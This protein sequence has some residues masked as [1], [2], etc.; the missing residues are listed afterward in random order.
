MFESIYHAFNTNYAQ[1]KEIAPHLADLGFTHIQFPPIQRTRVL[2]GSDLPLLQGQIKARE[3]HLQEYESL[4]LKARAKE[5]AYPNHTFTYLLEQRIYYI[6]QPLLRAIYSG[7]LAGSCNTKTKVDWVFS[8]GAWKRSRAAQIILSVYASKAPKKYPY[9][10]LYREAEL[11]VN[12]PT[13]PRADPGLQTKLADA[14][15]THQ[16]I[17][18]RIKSCS[19]GTVH[20]DLLQQSAECKKSY[21]RLKSLESLHI[22]YEKS[23][24]ELATL[25]AAATELRKQCLNDFS[26]VDVPL[27][28]HQAWS[29]LFNIICVAEFLLHPPWWMIYQPVRLA[30]GTTMH[31]DTDELYNAIHACKRAGLYVIAD[32]VVNNFAAIAG[33]RDDWQPYAQNRGAQTLADTDAVNSVTGKK[34]QTLLLDA[35][36]TD[37]LSA[38]TPPFECTTGQD[39]TQCWMSGALPQLNQDHPAVSEQQ[40]KF[41]ITLRGMGIDGVR[42][43]AAAHLR[44]ADCVR[45]IAMFPG[46]SYIE[47]VGGSESWRAYPDRAYSSVARLEDFAI[48]EDL[49]KHIFSEQ[50]Q[51]ERIKNYGHVRLQRHENLDSVVMIVNHD[52][53]MGSLPSAVFESLP[54]R[55]TY[56]LSLA[57]L[58]QRIYGTPLLM[59]HDIE[60]MGVHDALRFR[61]QMA[62]SNI[63]RE[64]VHIP[65]HGVVYIY[66]FNTNDECK[67]VSVFNLRESVLETVYGDVAAL[68]FCWFRVDSEP[69][70]NLVYNQTRSSWMRR[71]YRSRNGRRRGLTRRHPK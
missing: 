5:A 22:Q 29:A 57:Y 62:M 9:Y 66:K 38:L 4:C 46:L 59:P 28:S 34:L 18:E 14:Y 32:I 65:E 21:M 16:R 68:S 37:D 23:N 63:I 13:K 44:P 17:Q 70:L 47:Y 58:L 55:R 56:E 10:T 48:G 30:V 2:S 12:A 19:G 31:G 3:L 20:A 54:S 67:F 41:M 26:D 27:P 71:Y 15:A 42:I 60:F 49:Y 1:I 40:T 50:A 7:L 61:K 36:G 52:Q 39:P 51:F 11:V 64:Y 43:D 8:S 6:N 45:A 69:G 25:S 53:L 24:A 33:E 35:L